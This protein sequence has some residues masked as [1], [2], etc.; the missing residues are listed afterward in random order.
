[1][2]MYVL[3]IIGFSLLS[4]REPNSNYPEGQFASPLHR[5]FQLSGTFGE[6][7]V[8]HF[9]AGLDIKSAKGMIGDTVYAAAE[10]YISR[11]QVDAF[12]YGNVIYVDH[13]NGY[14]TVYGHLDRFAPVFQQYVKDEQ[15]RQ[16]QF[17][18]DLYPAPNQFPVNP[19]DQIGILGNTGHSYG[20]HLHFEIRHTDS[21]VP[22]NPLHF[23][24]NI[25][26]QIPPV[27]Q[28]LIAYQ[29]DDAGQLIQSTVL[30]PKLDS[31]G[32]YR[33]PAPFEIG[34]SRVTFGI[35]ACDYQDGVDNQNGIYSLQCTADG[36]PSFAF[37][38][39]EIPLQDTRYLNAHIDY[40][41]KI[42]QN[43]FFTRCYSLEGN[44]LP[45]YFSGADKGMIYL[46]TE[47]P[48]EVSISV[49]DFNG[50]ISKI[51]FEVVRNRNLFPP[52]ALMPPF[53][54]L[55]QPDE[56]SI[57]SKPGI[58]V[59]WPKGSFYERIP[60]DIAVLPGIAKGQFCPRYEISP[61]DIPVHYYF[62]IAIEG[63][64]IPSRLH[65]KAFI[66]RC[67]ANGSI[68]N[69][70]GTWVGHNVTSS[71]R[72]M[73][74]YTIL[75]DT[76]PPTISASKFSPNMSTWKKMSFKIADNVRAREKAKDLRYS[77]WVDGQWI[78]MA[79]DGKTGTLTHEFDGHI[80]PGEHQLIVKVW[81]DR[82][83]EGVLQKSFTL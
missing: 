70:G 35:R 25:P 15:Y 82:N 50:N 72:Q 63:H 39:D 41:Q 80:A 7:R 48:R 24:Y 12:G 6:L 33:L 53:E 64:N 67:D 34:V 32:I 5:Q 14:T 3:L 55:A 18:V 74:T 79:L 37:A 81:D 77:A 36:E 52:A 38:L 44:K 26:D 1:M 73:G 42:Y 69:C 75:V 22:V 49:G 59:V 23:G 40:Q 68:A 47:Q 66:A 65:D 54:L 57:L 56:V 29:F 43:R 16:Q 28:Q 62:D 58:Q 30:Q 71:A 83:N 13:P 10:G 20:P 61:S 60:L 9:H 8:N 46:N 21:Q 4:M 2:R 27:I 51:N 76:I 11:I 45:I 78:L 19:S 31:A 17:E